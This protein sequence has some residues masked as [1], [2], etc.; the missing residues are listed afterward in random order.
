MSKTVNVYDHIPKCLDQATFWDFLVALSGL[1][2]YAGRINAAGELELCRKSD[3][4]AHAILIDRARAHT[5]NRQEQS[6]PKNDD[7]QTTGTE[8]TEA[9]EQG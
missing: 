2:D 3:L 8:A 6:E 7:R 1:D 4:P 9:E 5:Q